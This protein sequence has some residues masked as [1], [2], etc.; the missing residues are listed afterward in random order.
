MYSIEE[1]RIANWKKCIY[2]FN[3]G[4]SPQQNNDI[5]SSIIAIYPKSIAIPQQS[6]RYVYGPWVTN[7]T[8]PYGMKIEYEQV[9]SLVPEAF[10]LPSNADPNTVSGF[11]GMNTAGQ[12][13]ADTVEGFDYLFTESASVSIPDY[14][15]ITYLGQALIQGGPLVTD[16]SISTT[17]N[18]IVTDYNMTTFAPKFGRTNKNTV[19]IMSKLA[20]RLNNLRLY[21]TQ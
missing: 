19:D 20:K 14:P 4:K 17:A 16:I 21:R 7:V 5:P 1:E 11:D 18:G 13:L 10:V 12:L 3:M 9:D 15:D 8:L 2:N 6:N